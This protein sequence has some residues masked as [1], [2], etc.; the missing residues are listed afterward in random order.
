MNARFL[1]PGLGLVVLFAG[2]ANDASVCTSSSKGACIHRIKS[3][4]ELKARIEA[5]EGTAV[6]ALDRAHDECGHIPG[7]SHVDN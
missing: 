5:H 7:A 3:A 4:K 1:I 6:H 2:C